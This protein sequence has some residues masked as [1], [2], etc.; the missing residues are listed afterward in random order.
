MSDRPPGQITGDRERVLGAIRAALSTPTD[1]HVQHAPLSPDRSTYANGLPPVAD[2]VDSMLATF[3]TRCEALRATLHVVTDAAAAREAIEA[4]LASE[5][6]TR[7][8]WHRD[9]LVSPL[10]DALDPAVA[11]VCVDDGF[12]AVAL[13]SCPVGL[14]GCFALVAQT[15]S[16][17]V[18]SAHTGGRSLSVL[19]PHHVV[20]A[21]IDQLLPTLP[22][23]FAAFRERGG[24]SS[25]LSFISGP[26]RTGD[27]ERILVL[28]AHGPKRLT[29]VLIRPA[30][31]YST[32]GNAG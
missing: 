20:V 18:T 21:T 5:H 13:E 17:L 25:M 22:A 30:T 11:R 2:D 7:I 28:G 6:A 8:A 1:P 16:V 24:D 15:G 9:P 26:S 32:G 14:T 3:T 31:A 10:V 19:P 23:A 27:I 12:D 4:V 29:I